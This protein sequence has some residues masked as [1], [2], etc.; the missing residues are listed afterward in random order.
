MKN[1]IISNANCSLESQ[2]AKRKAK[3]SREKEGRGKIAS[4]MGE[5][6][7]SASEKT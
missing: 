2:V 5:W 4:K 7:T 6:D 1:F 3:G